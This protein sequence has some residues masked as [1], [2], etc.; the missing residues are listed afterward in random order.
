MRPLKMSWFCAFSSSFC[1][2]I[3]IYVIRTFPKRYLTELTRAECL[4]CN[5]CQTILVNF[6]ISLLV[7]LPCQC[8][9]PN[10]S[11]RHPSI[12][13]TAWTPPQ[14]TV[15][16]FSN[17][18]GRCRSRFDNHLNGLVLG[19]RLCFSHFGREFLLCSDCPLN[20]GYPYVSSFLWGGSQELPQV[21]LP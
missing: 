13:L 8:P 11:H 3:G 9:T 17:L 16:N 18:S 2:K 14:S 7:Q 4:S 1:E 15:T 6:A 19:F 21:I 20:C 12:A 5:S 10:P